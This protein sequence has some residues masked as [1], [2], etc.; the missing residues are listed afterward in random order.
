MDAG[1][2][3]VVHDV[4]AEQHDDERFLQVLDTSL[5]VLD[6]LEVPYLVIGEIGS[7]IF[8][9]DRGTRD[10]D[11]FVRP[12]AAP[13]VLEG[14]A[15]AGFDTDV[16]FEHWLFK[17][18]SAD[19][20]VDIIFRAARDILLDEAMMDRTSIQP[21]RGRI[22]TARSSTQA[23]TSIPTSAPSPASRRSSGSSGPVPSGRPSGWRS[24]GPAGPSPRSPRGTRGGES[25]SGLWSP[26]LGASRRRRRCSTRWS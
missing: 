17:A 3:A 20:D 6:R 9:R 22:V 11:L 8:G 14:F 19:V 10:I 25:T 24:V 15:A 18:R 7:S 12:E 16:I 13:R 26:A 21:F 4:T 1:M 2:H 5:A 23:I